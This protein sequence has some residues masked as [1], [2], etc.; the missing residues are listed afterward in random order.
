MYLRNYIEK[1]IWRG[2]ET[3]FCDDEREHRSGW[4][5]ALLSAVGV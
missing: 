4:S 3:F 2:I 1:A 5:L